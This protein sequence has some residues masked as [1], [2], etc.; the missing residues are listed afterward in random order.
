VDSVVVDR[1]AL[2]AFFWASLVR[3]ALLHHVT[4]SINSICHTIG[5]RPFKSRTS[6]ATC[7]GWRS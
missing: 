3:I 1:G 7:G 6:P 5:D 4:W 2:T